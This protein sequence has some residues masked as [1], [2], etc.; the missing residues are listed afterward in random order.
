[1]TVAQAVAAVCASEHLTEDFVLQLFRQNNN[2][3]V[4]VLTQLSYMSQEQKDKYRYPHQRLCVKTGIDE[5]ICKQALIECNNDE[6]VALQY[7]TITNN[8]E[9]KK[10][11]TVEMGSRLSK[12]TGMDFTECM[13]L[14]RRTNGD[15]EEAVRIISTMDNIKREITVEMGSRLSKRTGMDFTECMNLLRKSNGDEEKAVE[16]ISK[17][18]S[19]KREITVEMGSSLS[20][21]TGMDFTECMNLLRKTNGDEEEAVKIISGMSSFKREI[22]VE[23]GSSLS[24]RTGV[25]F[26]E[27]MNFLRRTNGD[28]EKA[29]EMVFGKEKAKRD[30]LS[31]ESGFV[32]HG[33]TLVEYKGNEECV[34]IPSHV[35]TIGSEAFYNN[36]RV[37]K[38]VLPQN[39][40][41]EDEAFRDCE[42]LQSL[43]QNGEAVR[44]SKLGH[45]A[46]WGCEKLNTAIIFTGNRVGS[47]AFYGCS[48]ITRVLLKNEL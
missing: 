10:E 36:T 47:N 24:K 13:N 9:V 46:F 16:I 38:V 29:I 27:C 18:S 8:A 7:L 6:K 34:I 35:D 2:G 31:Y 19:I 33:N 4:S 39:I 43:S 17:M 23:M 1:M 14:L 15:E 3:L 44:I 25:D 30:A 12:R 21:R 32:I 42:N 28:E 48:S 20:K 45:S 41:I 37:K 11:I 22:T 26:T 5:E 40:S